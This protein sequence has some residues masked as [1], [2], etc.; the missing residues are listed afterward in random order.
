[1]GES[2]DFPTTGIASVIGLQAALDAKAASG[3]PAGGVFVVP[4]FQGAGNH[5]LGLKIK[6]EIPVTATGR[7]T[8]DVTFSTLTETLGFRVSFNL[9][10]STF[11]NYS[12]T[13][14]SGGNIGTQIN[15]CIQSGKVSLGISVAHN[16]PKVS[17]IATSHDVSTA[18]YFT[19]W[20]IIN[21]NGAT[22]LV[23][24]AVFAS[25][26]G[27]ITGT[28]ATFSGNISAVRGTYSE[29]LILTTTA[30]GLRTDANSK[31][32]FLAGGTSPSNSNG[33]YIY[34]GGNTSGVAGQI[35]LV[36][37]DVGGGCVS[38]WGGSGPTNMASFNRDLTTTWH[39]TTLADLRGQIVRTG[40][41]VTAWTATPATGYLNTDGSAVS[42]TTYAA[43]FAVIGT[44][45]GVGDGSTTFNLP[46]TTGLNANGVYFHIK[47]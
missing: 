31:Y 41:M 3:N 40:Y 43:L 38:I 32:L 47:T 30:N 19:G 22:D 20:T 23:A 27:P 12:A 26:L 18:S 46:N 21:E 44:T 13:P 14:L 15:L 39:A 37:G 11:A 33:A 28:T 16:T 42:R 4:A 36:S 7:Y 45:F 35:N 24:Q 25:H 1:M 34:V 6:T 9:A 10:S 29:S 17:V 5:N 8:L 2:H